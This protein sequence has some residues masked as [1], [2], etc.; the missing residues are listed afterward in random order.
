MAST[1]LDPPQ[2]PASGGWSAVS[3]PPTTPSPALVERDGA[4]AHYWRGHVHWHRGHHAA[5]EEELQ[6]ATDLAETHDPQ[7]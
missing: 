5:A 6:A 1:V 4:E 7:H 3:P 2:R